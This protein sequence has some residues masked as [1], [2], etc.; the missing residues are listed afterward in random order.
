MLTPPTGEVAARLPDNTKVVFD[1]VG[2]LHLAA[3]Q[4]EAEPASLVKLREAGDA[5]L[6]RVDLPEV[7]L[8]VF[9]WTGARRGVY[10]D[11]RR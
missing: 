10:L 6:P 7:L 9:A 11:H 2:R 8:E 3:L 4:P 1:D 5:M